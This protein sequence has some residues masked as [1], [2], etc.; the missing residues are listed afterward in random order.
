MLK[1]RETAKRDRLRKSTDFK[2]ASMD[3][4]SLLRADKVDDKAIAAKLVEVQAAQGALLK[5]RVDQALAM[6]RILTPEQQ[7]KMAEM[8][9]AMMGQGPGRMRQP[10]GR[11]MGRGMGGDGF[12]DF[13]DLDPEG[14]SIR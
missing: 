2:I 4:K 5:V 8:R 9:G 14:P 10:R 3:L 7:K 1:A 13:D 6:K 12:D 11:G